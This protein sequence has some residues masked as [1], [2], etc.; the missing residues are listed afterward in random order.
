MYFVL[1]VPQREVTQLICLIIYISS[2]QLST[3]NAKPDLSVVQNKQK[4]K[5]LKAF[6]SVP[7]YEKGFKWQKEIPDAIMFHLAID[8]VPIYAVFK[9]D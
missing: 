2:T 6:A 5:N 4:V 9:D 1:T 3:T 7:P 8:K